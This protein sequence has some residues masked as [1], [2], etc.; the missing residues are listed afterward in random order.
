MGWGRE[1]EEIQN[2]P[3]GKIEKVNSVVNSVI[4]YKSPREVRNYC[5]LN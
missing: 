3:N 2:N 5:T 1:E 4:G